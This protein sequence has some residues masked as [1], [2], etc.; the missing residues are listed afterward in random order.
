MD[1]RAGVL[2]RYTDGGGRAALGF[3]PAAVASR[4]AALASLTPVPGVPPPAVGIALADGVVVTVLAV[5]RSPAPPAYEPDDGWPVPGADR[6]LLCRVG[7]LDLALTGGVVLATGVFDAAPGGGVVWRGAPVPAL[8]VAAL[9]A[10]AEAA[11]WADRVQRSSPPP[12]APRPADDEGR[13]TW[14]PE[15]PSS[16]PST[17][18]ERS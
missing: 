13:W 9:Y 12:A 14:L 15:P 5:G 10:Q 11:V 16:A 1:E 7:G 2:L 18:G 3:V 6:A 4:L 8:D 17:M